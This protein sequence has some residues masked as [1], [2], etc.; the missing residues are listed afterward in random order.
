MA[1]WVN[2]GRDSKPVYGK[3]KTWG[4]NLEGVDAWVLE[5][6]WK[7]WTKDRALEGVEG[8]KAGIF[9]GWNFRN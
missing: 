1:G 5:G 9:E 6:S 2:R 7:N 4:N 8:A 3:R